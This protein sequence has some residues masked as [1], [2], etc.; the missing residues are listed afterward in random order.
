[1][2]QA[3]EEDPPPQKKISRDSKKRKKYRKN[4][5]KDR[6]HYVDPYSYPSI[7]KEGQFSAPSKAANKNSTT[8]T[9]QTPYDHK[10]KRKVTEASIVLSGVD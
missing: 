4:K 8:A 5:E 10:N 9:K 1:M 7:F 3:M 2:A 6:I